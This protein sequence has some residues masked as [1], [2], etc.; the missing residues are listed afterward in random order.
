MTSTIDTGNFHVQ[1][2]TKEG[3]SSQALN[4]VT[5]DTAHAFYDGLVGDRTKGNVL[6]VAIFQWHRELREWAMLDIW[7]YDQR[8]F[9]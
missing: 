8:D 2:A 6:F 1:W 9:N 4:G 7:N 3:F 5:P